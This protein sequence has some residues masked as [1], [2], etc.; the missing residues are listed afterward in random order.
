MPSTA[1][2]SMNVLNASMSLTC[3]V[4]IDPTE[5][6]TQIDQRHRALSSRTAVTVIVVSLSSLIC[7]LFIILFGL[8]AAF[9]RQA[10]SR[11]FFSQYF[12]GLVHL[13]KSG[14]HW[15]FLSPEV[16]ACKLLKPVFQNHLSASA[17]HGWHVFP[18]VDYHFST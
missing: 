13:R 4:R 8:V 12:Y 3:I 16:A 1:D 15:D 14:P 10:A 7:S 2:A 6:N 11:R 18:Y 17:P 5:V 9:L